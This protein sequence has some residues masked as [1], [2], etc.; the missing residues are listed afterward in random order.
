MQIPPPGTPFRYA[1]SLWSS[2]LKC[3]ATKFSPSLLA[4][5]LLLV[6]EL[7]E[8]GLLAKCFLTW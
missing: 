6:Q 4:L 3:D 1:N 5:L 2:Q 7:C 8:A